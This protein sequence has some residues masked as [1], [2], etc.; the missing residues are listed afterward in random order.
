MEELKTMNGV[1]NTYPTLDSLSFFPA[2]PLPL[3]L[4]KP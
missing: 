4:S 1:K 3:G 2:F